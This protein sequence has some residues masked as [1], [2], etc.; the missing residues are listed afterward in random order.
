MDGKRKLLL[1]TIAGFT[2]QITAIICGF[3]LPRYIL[4]YFGSSVNGL[5]NT[6]IHYLSF[7]SLL[8]MGVG[9]VVISNFYCPLAINDAE[10]TSR[11]YKASNR[12]FR[13][14]ALIFVGYVAVLVFIFPSIVNEGYDTIYT[15]SL[16]IIIAT[17]TFVEYFFGMTNN[18]LLQADQK[19][20]ISLTMFSVTTLFNTAISVRLIIW[21]ANIQTVK[22]A[23]ALVFII[24]PLAQ[25]LYVR[26]H[27]RID[28][29][30]K[31]D[32]EP[33]KQK[34]NGFSQ[35][36]SAVVCQNVDI[37]ALSFFSTMENVSIYS[38]YYLVVSGLTQ[39]VMTAS[40]GIESF[41][42][43][44]IAKT[45]IEKLID[46]FEKIEF[47]GHIIVAMAFTAAAIL[48]VPFVMIYTK[49]VA[50]AANYCQPLFAILMVSAYAVRCLRVPYFMVI[51]AAGHYKQT[52][53]GAFIAAVI[54]VVIT[55]ALVFKFGLIG[56]AVGT[57]IA[58]AY[59]TIYF[60]FYLRTN[61]LSRSIYKFIRC[62]AADISIFVISFLT[63]S[64]I[65]F[66]CTS[67]T[68]WILYAIAVGVIILLVS[69]VIS[70]LLFRNN[71]YA[72]YGL[73]KT[74]RSAQGLKH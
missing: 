69:A 18:L 44:L 16:L 60:V 14:L 36:L 39:L 33:N 2:K 5:V 23:S 20:Y 13:Y 24:R 15:V 74:G 40:T 4:L 26:R 51:K 31:I 27:Y 37:M 48:I 43:N 22:L 9:A 8:D 64:F 61:I 34:W 1:N 71:L 52:Q 53:N 70:V 63:T 11:I 41:F 10:Q 65:R 54:N 12:F 45:E 38:V 67:Y 62:L 19:A 66:E 57:L 46:V 50:D 25:E 28:K 68:E 47:A 73:I 58:L 30:I 21:G 6:M 17:S 42:G 72:L 7:I 35:H 49:G 55:V 59:H 56:A 3:I 32:K 29:T